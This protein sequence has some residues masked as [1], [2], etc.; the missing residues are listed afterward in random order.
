MQK[1]KTILVI[2]MFISTNINM[3]NAASG[4]IYYGENLSQFFAVPISGDGQFA[5]VDASFT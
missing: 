5:V 1:L 4:D 3:A 2:T